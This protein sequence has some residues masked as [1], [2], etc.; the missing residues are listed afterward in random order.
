[1]L[2]STTGREVRVCEYTPTQFASTL[3]HSLGYGSEI[4]GS[5]MDGF[6]KIVPPAR[7]ESVACNLC[8]NTWHWWIYCALLFYLS[9]DRHFFFLSLFISRHSL[10]SLF[11]L[12]TFIDFFIIYLFIL[13]S[14]FFLVYLFL[15]LANILWILS[16]LAVTSYSILLLIYLH[17]LLLIFVFGIF[18]IFLFLFFGD[19]IAVHNF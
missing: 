6:G 7:I 5:V 19:I 16:L 11:W 8:R 14:S 15:Y 13:Y 2:K 10:L 4:Y 12:L 9:I 1:M 18:F 3:P 17:A